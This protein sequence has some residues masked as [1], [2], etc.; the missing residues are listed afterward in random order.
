MEYN[1]KYNNDCIL[2]DTC[3]R[4][5]KVG[6]D[7]GCTIQPEFM[8]LYETS[9]I[10]KNM[11]QKTTLYPAKRDNEAFCTLKDIQLDI[12]NFVDDGRILYLW[13]NNSGCGKAQ[14]LYSKLLTPSG[15]IT[16]GEVKVGDEVFGEDGK[17]HRVLG[18][19]PQGKK[20]VYELTFNDGAK[21]RCS[22]E[23]LWTVSTNC[24]KS[25]KTLTLKEIHSSSLCR[26]PN[27]KG[28][29]GKGWKYHIP[30]TLPIEFNSKEAN[31]PLDPWLLGA[32]IG[33]GGFTRAS[34][35]FSNTEEDILDKVKGKIMCY[36]CTLVSAQNCE[37]RIIQ[38]SNQGNM[39]DIDNKVE[40]T[41]RSKLKQLGLAD[42]KS[43]Q[44]FIPKEYLCAGVDNRLSL[45][46][47][48]F[49]TD[50]TVDSRGYYHFSTSSKQLAEDI[51]FLVQSLGG[52]CTCN[53][54][55]AFYTYKG[56]KRQGLNN[57]ELYIKLPNNMLPFTSKKHLSKVKNSNFRASIYRTLRAIDYI[58]KEECQ[59]ILVDNPSH[60]YLT[61][62]M[63]VT[64]N[65]E[66]ACKLLK[67]YLAVICIGNGFKD[68]AR[69]IYVPSLLLLAK[70]FNDD[71]R[72]T[73]L[74]MLNTL[75]L[76]ILDD[77]GAVQN[78]NYD[79]TILSDII[80]TRY[81]NGLSTVYTSNLSPTSLE[82]SIGSR[83]KDRICS[84]IVIELKGSSHRRGT[85][86]YK[87]RD[88]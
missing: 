74:D 66:W 30:V 63:I 8:Y 65:T 24:R 85:N 82:Q 53:E 40:N 11:M 18:V 83:L 78:S 19:Y 25:W 12:D 62:N 76:V 17:P 64:H 37:Y 4:H 60:L 67:T 61:D 6:C 52:T 38:Q 35:S 39:L 16:M 59:C 41:I 86:T 69:F 36:G 34:T 57:F 84:D 56:E 88:G 14:P 7:A 47:G 3:P 28:K 10:P 79:L 45:L 1:Y 81:R 43:D 72:Q 31:L 73:T 23:H 15:Y 75:D 29:Q 70:E 21:C 20:D 44:K 22:D 5:Q 80:D 51:V 32:L 46:Q 2:K 49:D 87:R 9:G 50:G 55:E 71:S 33:D 77:I 13:S 54:H 27:A 48:L 68:R 26:N 42:H 58:G